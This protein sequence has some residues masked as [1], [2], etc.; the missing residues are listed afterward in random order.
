MWLVDYY[1]RCDEDGQDAG[2]GGAG[3]GNSRP[4]GDH[5]QRAGAEVCCVRASNGKFIFIV[6]FFLVP[7]I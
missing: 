3:E 4:G 6:G 2:E 7:L 1:N 5:A